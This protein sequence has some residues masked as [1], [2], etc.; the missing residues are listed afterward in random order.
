MSSSADAHLGYGILAKDPEHRLC[1]LSPLFGDDD[2]TDAWEALDLFD[3]DPCVEIDWAGNLYHDS[4]QMV[5]RC[6]EPYKSVYYGAQIIELPC[7][8]ETNGQNGNALA[9]LDVMLRGFVE[10]LQLDPEKLEAPG[11]LLWATYG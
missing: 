2:D 8:Y 4:T 1:D 11:W 9:Y 7:G 10:K 6:R 5:I 3:A